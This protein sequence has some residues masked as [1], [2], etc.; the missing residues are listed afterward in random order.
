M[1]DKILFDLS[2]HEIG[3]GVTSVADISGDQSHSSPH[4]D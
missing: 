4:A 2:E 3:V 1:N